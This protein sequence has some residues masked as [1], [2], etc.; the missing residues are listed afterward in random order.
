M[1]FS[2]LDIA[3]LIERGFIGIETDP[4]FRPLDLD[5]QLQ[6]AS[7]D[8]RLG[9]KFQRWHAY[10][11]DSVPIDVTQPPPVGSYTETVIAEGGKFVI[12]PGEFVLG[13]TVERVRLP[14]HIA[15]RI[16][17]RSSLGRYGV[18][19]HVTAGFIDPGFEGAITLEIANL[20]ANP[21]VLTAGM[22]V[23]QL[24]FHA[25]S[26]AAIAPYKGKYQGQTSTTASG[27]TEPR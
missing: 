26:S 13:T 1:I 20:N 25:M 21:I 22:R 2:D 23:G 14:A 8:V 7:L 4:K 16:E 27:G 19:V 11:W 9:G 10:E 6:P 12:K 5:V 17:G 3:Q 24:V 18:T 15:G